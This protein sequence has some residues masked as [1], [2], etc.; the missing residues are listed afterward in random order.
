MEHFDVVIV[1]AGMSGLAAGVRIAHFGKRVLILEKHTLWGG[2]NSFYKKGGHHFDVGLHAV[3]NWLRPG[4]KGPRLPLQRIYRQ[5]RI[6]PDEFAL[7]PQT[8]S[9]VV[10]DDARLVF[11]NDIDALTEEVRRV[12]PS[13]VDGFVR[14][15]KRC[16]HY[17]EA[18]EATPFVSA[19]KML[20]EYLSEP[21]LIEMLLCPLFFYGSAA[22][23]D[24]DFEQFI[25]L[26]N[27]IY[28]E[29]FCRPR[30]GV[31]QILDVLVKR[32]EELGGE[33]RRKCAVES[34]EIED[35]RVKALHT[36]KGTVTADVVLS[37]AG[38]VE[39]QAL[40]SDVESPEVDKAGRLAFTET[41]WVLDQDPKKLGFD[42]CVT[43]FN[44]GPTFAWRRPDVPVDLRSGVICVPSNYD[45]EEPLERHLLRATH[46][47][48]HR[49]WMA[50][51]EDR[52]KYDAEKKVWTER[53]IETIGRYGA[54]FAEHIRYTDGFTPRTVKHFTSHVHGAVYG[55][56]HKQKTGRT[57]VDNLFLMGTDQGFVGIVGA[58]LSGVA[59]ANAHVLSGGA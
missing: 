54:P 39:T 3:T 33:M 16:L 31:K 40:R 6:K 36:A 32:Y 55:S 50:L 1:G 35:G 23:D 45:H 12:F 4:Y 49:Y 59:M 11:A 8:R 58:M 19:R 52:E 29:G 15:S 47:A 27:S 5:L 42:D 18:N 41:L 43:F 37:S 38:L 51:A 30:R 25:I 17:P 2:L 22:E 24:V 14:L 34:I 9:S 53:S 28:R 13:Q 44:E 20:T 21:L 26:F 48:D 10:F 46:L 7:E 56:P 57:D